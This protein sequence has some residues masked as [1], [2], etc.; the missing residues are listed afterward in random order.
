MFPPCDEFYDPILECCHPTVAVDI[1][2]TLF[3]L[4]PVQCFPEAIIRKQNEIIRYCFFND[5]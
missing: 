4:D 3:S 2:Q 5:L 1:L